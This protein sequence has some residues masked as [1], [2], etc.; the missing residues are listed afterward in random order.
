MRT[1]TL[2]LAA[3]VMLIGGG[4]AWAGT[5]SDSFNVTATVV[6]NCQI[7]TPNTLAFGNYDP[8]SAT[9]T[10]G[11]TTFQVRCTKGTS[12][13]VGLNDGLN[14]TR[15]MASG[16]NLLDYELYQDSARTT[17]WGNTSATG[18]AYNAT[19]NG[20]FTLTVYGRIPAGQDVPAGSY[21]DTVTATINF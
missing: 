17:V 16:T 12:A 7:Q 4:L 10:D 5:A 20:W 13:W 6:T 9:P 15:F 3:M 1:K 14:G 2:T 19:N 21:L 8:L 11:S 18:V